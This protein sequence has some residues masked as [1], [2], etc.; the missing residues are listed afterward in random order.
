V[1]RD[2]PQTVGIEDDRLVEAVEEVAD[3]SADGVRPPDPGPD[4]D[5]RGLLGRL[6]DGV[7]RVHGHDPVLVR[8]WPAHHLEQPLFEDEIQ[9]RGHADRHDPRPRPEGGLSGQARRAGLPR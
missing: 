8:A 1:A 9:R 6:E 2:G 5:G 3:Q 4:R 7:G